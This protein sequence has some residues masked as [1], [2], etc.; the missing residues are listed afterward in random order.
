MYSWQKIYTAGKGNKTLFNAK[1]MKTTWDRYKLPLNTTATGFVPS[2]IPFLYLLTPALW[3]GWICWSLAQLPWS[4]SR[5]HPGQKQ[6][7]N[8]DT[9]SDSHLETVKEFPPDSPRMHVLDCG[10]K[11]QRHKRNMVK[12]QEALGSNLQP[13]CYE[14]T[15]LTTA[16]VSVCG[17]CSRLFGVV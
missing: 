16:P 8:R 6:R 1:V 10:R 14:V 3:H 11:P 4:G 5:V 15:A 2:S 17:L 13:S 7:I 12:P 9:D